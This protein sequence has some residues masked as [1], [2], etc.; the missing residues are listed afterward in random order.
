L[1][2]ILLWIFSF[3]VSP[4][5]VLDGVVD[6]E[7]Q[8]LIREPGVRRQQRGDFVDDGFGRASPKLLAWK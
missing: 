1:I 4:H 6:D 8:L 7:V 5:P 2:C 3:R